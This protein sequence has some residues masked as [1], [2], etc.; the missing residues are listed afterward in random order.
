MP[1]DWGKSSG[2]TTTAFIKANSL[3]GSFTA[4][5]SRAIL[6]SGVFHVVEFKK[7]TERSNGNGIVED[8]MEEE[9]EWQIYMI[10]VSQHSNEIRAAS[11]DRFLLPPQA[12]YITSVFPL[13]AF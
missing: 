9:E 2:R 11:L 8:R 12:D 5:I 13:L 6:K 7:Q 3:D 1:C 4:F 10:I